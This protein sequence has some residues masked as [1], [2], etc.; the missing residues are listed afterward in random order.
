M[1]VVVV[2]VAVMVRS[3]WGVNRSLKIGCITVCMFNLLQS[4]VAQ[5]PSHYTVA[6][7]NANLKKRV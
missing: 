7:K 4:R 6:Q 3:K 2:V 5:K 1:V